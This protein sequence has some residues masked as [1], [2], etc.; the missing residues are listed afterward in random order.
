MNFFKKVLFS[1]CLFIFST[2]VYSVGY[3]DV[4][5]TKTILQLLFYLLVFVVVIF[6]TLYGTKLIAKNHKK[7]TGSK[8][9]QLI[10]VLN[11]QTGI[12]LAIVNINKKIYIL[13]ISNTSTTVIDTIDEQ[14]FVTETF[15]NYLNKHIIKKDIDSLN[16]NIDIK[17][18]INKLKFSKDEEDENEEKF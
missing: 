9:I 4:S 5:L 1:A 3:E 12:K 15:D 11:M 6:V 18:L 16:F 14:D 2:P 13:S 8:Y 17:K 10:D 7:F